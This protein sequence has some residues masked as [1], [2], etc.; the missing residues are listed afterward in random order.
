MEPRIEVETDPARIFHDRV[1]RKSLLLAKLLSENPS[2]L[3]T[4]KASLLELKRIARFRAVDYKD[5]KVRGG[6]ISNDT[7][8]WRIKT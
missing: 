1:C 2:V 7:I 6:G 5:L 4:V 8:F 3:S